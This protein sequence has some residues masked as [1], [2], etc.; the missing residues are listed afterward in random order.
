MK[1]CIYLFITLILF[2]SSCDGD[3]KDIQ[4]EKTEWV[5]SYQNV[6]I[7]T[8][9]QYEVTNTAVEY[10][11]YGEMNNHMITIQ[12]MN[13]TYSGL[14]SIRVYEYDYLKEELDYVSIPAGQSYTFDFY[15]PVVNSYYT[16][17]QKSNTV[18]H[19]KKIESLKKEFISVNSCNE[20]IEALK[21]RYKTIEEL[22]ISK[23][24]TNIKKDKR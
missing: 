18:N 10:S 24:R 21:D 1:Y 11:K 13:Q 20:N 9:V 15:S 7:D 3:C 5:T 22:Y 6:I 23:T 4:I 19:K 17:I 14:F 12:N 16:I 8:T 2:I